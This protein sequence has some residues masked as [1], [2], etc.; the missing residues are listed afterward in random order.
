M[1]GL[2]YHCGATRYREP[3]V[4]T[5]CGLSLRR[6]LTDIKN[7]LLGLARTKFRPD[8]RK[9]KHAFYPPSTCPRHFL[10]AESSYSCSS[11]MFFF[12]MGN[13]CFSALPPTVGWGFIVLLLTAGWRTMLDYQVF[14]PRSETS[15]IVLR[16]VG[17]QGTR[18]YL[19]SCRRANK[20]FL[21]PWLSGAL[22]DRD[23]REPAETTFL[24]AAKCW[25]PCS[26]YSVMW[27]SSTSL[28]SVTKSL[29]WR[30][31]HSSQVLFI[32][33]VTCAGPSHGDAHCR[34]FLLCSC[35]A[36]VRWQ[37]CDS[38]CE[39]A[40]VRQQVWGGRCVM[41][42]VGRQVWDCRCEMA[43]VRWQ[44]W[45]GRYGRGPES[46]VGDVAQR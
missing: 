27:L 9:C 29:R 25:S 30:P 22:F 21:H 37:V 39:M 28:S 41:A 33:S 36:G 38:R 31:H 45:D 10:Q 16:H 2:I 40:G 32:R 12:T 19:R 20:V 34:G 43:G 8:R 26:S 17:R 44:V 1:P 42:G 4:D 7:M 5:F 15:N 3:V 18:R 23:L 6:T 24:P 35:N 14:K 13:Y 46:K 11:W